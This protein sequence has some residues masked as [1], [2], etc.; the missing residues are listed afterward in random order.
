MYALYLNSGLRSTDILTTLILGLKQLE[1]KEKEVGRAV[2]K[3]IGKQVRIH[4]VQYSTV[5]LIEKKRRSNNSKGLR[6]LGERREKGR[7][8]GRRWVGQ[9]WNE[10][11]DIE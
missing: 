9:A 11:T 6:R 5:K 1:K 4:I 2:D 3:C 7:L 8:V 10:V